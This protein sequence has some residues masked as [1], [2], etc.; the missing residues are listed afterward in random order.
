MPNLKQTLGFGTS[1]ALFAAALLFCLG[2]TAAQTPPQAALCSA[3]HGPQGNSQ[4]PTIPSLAGQ[5][6]VFLENQLVL[7]REGMRE[8]P[9]MKGIMD[10]IQDADIS[11]LAKYFA[12]QTPTAPPAPSDAKSFAQGQ[13]LARAALCGTC[14]LPNYSG[15]NQIPRLAAQQE[16]YLRDTMLQ[17]RDN[18]APGRDTAMSAVLYGLSNAQLKDLAHFFAHFK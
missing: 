15:Q 7:I 10:P 18:P 2:S 12:A 5:P 8:I 14:H 17:Y 9:V 3:C 4:I 16:T 11:A 1:R 13:E 6:K